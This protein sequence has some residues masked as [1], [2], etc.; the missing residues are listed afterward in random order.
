MSR[1]QIVDRPVILP[2]KCMLCSAGSEDRKYVDMDRSVD[3]YGRLYLCSECVKEVAKLCHY[4]PFRELAVAEKKNELFLSKIEG[5]QLKVQE[6][7]NVINSLRSLDSSDT[8]PDTSIPEK[9]SEPVKRARLFDT[10]FDEPTSSSKPRNVSAPTK[11][12]GPN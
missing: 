5:Y 12:F 3:R 8:K 9:P 10:E 6:L 2:Q 4:V 1:A 7:K 11:L